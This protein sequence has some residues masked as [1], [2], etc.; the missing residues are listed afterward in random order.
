MADNKPNS[1]AS[2]EM[3]ALT[4]VAVEH[5][6]LSAARSQPGFKD[7]E[8]LGPRVE[9]VKPGGKVLFPNT[10][11]GRA[12]INRL[13]AMKAIETPEARR[14]RESALKPRDMDL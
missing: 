9:H 1:P 4:L 7:V 6:A 2:I 8:H 14:I 5:Q 11:E 3:V 12:D 13:V 10:E